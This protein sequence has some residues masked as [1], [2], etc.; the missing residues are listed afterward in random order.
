[1]TPETDSHFLTCGG[2]ASWADILFR[3][4]DDLTRQLNLTPW[5]H[6]TISTNL[7]RFLN[8]TELQCPNAWIAPAYNL[9]STIGWGACF[10][11][12]FST[13]WAKSQDLA[14]PTR[15]SGNRICT[16]IISLIF[17]ALIKRWHEQNSQLHQST[18]SNETRLRIE[19]KVRAL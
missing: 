15:H 9:Q 14:Q 12:I 6:H 3:P 10:Y 13:E 1:M 4:L 5:V 7:R 18:H 17:N 2:A 11:G 19:D 8:Q 16:K